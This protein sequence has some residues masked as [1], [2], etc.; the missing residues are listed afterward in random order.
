[1]C[2]FN[3]SINQNFLHHHLRRIFEEWILFIL[4]TTQD[5]L[6]VDTIYNMHYEFFSGDGYNYT[7]HYAVYLG[8][9]HYLYYALGSIFGDV[10][11]ILRRFLAG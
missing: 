3:Q 11:Y 4:C 5:F 2:E 8:R 9:G 6:S 1:M 7:M 10:Y